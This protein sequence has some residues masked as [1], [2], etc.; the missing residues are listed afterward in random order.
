[1]N[2]MW[3][4]HE[5]VG[6]T[7]DTFRTML[8][9]MKEYPQFR[10]SQSQASVYRILERFAPEMLEE[11]RQRVR[12]GRWEVTASTWVENDKNLPS[13]ESLLRQYL[14]AKRYLC[15]LFDLRPEDLALDFEPDTFGHS[16][17][18]PE[19]A[20]SAG[21]KYYYHCRGRETHE[22]ISRWRP[23]PGRSC[24]CIPSPTGTTR[25]SAPMWQSRR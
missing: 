16:A 18:V 5:T 10:F 24:C 19:V 12:E 22:L 25:T 6:T 20:A 13:G 15:G 9:I 3:G 11:V 23:P 7:I 21:V 8:Q 14:L 4:F 2:W 1:M 17:Y